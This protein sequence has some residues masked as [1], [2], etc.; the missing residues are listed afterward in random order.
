M[1]KVISKILASLLSLILVFSTLS[2]AVEKHE[3]GG[4]ITDIALFSPSDKCSP[5]MENETSKHSKQLG[6]NKQIC[7]KDLTQ[8]VQSTIVVEKTTKSFK[9][10]Q[11]QLSL[12]VIHFVNTFEGLQENI[13]PFQKYIPQ[14]IIRDIPVLYQSFLI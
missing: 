3:C 13:I 6:F 1:K 5:D 12:P 2:L 11:L 4:K 14:K 8:V 9:I 10:Q 7:C